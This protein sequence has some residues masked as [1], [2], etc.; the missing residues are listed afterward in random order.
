MSDQVYRLGGE[1][2]VPV[3]PSGNLAEG[4]LAGTWVKIEPAPSTNGTFCKVSRSNGADTPYGFLIYGPQHNRP[5]ESLSDM[6]TDGQRAGGDF[7]KDWTAKDASM[8]Y[9]FD[10]VGLLQKSGTKIASMAI[11]NEG[12]FKFYIF[13]VNNLA[14][15]TSPGS[16]A[17][18]VYTA[19]N[20][21]YVSSNGL[22]TSEQESVS[23]K[24][25]GY[26]VLTSSSDI[27]GN[28]LIIAEYN[29]N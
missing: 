27:G 13:E 28:F 2:L 25:C 23:H 17:P 5:V 9:E 7:H 29:N 24:T 22:L 6:W 14:E 16:G 26:V 19:G 8:D 18:L 21:L 10:D 15:R 11:S 3:E 1:L 20:P 4:W 12:V